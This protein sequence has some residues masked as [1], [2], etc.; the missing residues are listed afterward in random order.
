VR[1]SALRIII[2]GYVGA[3]PVGG[4]AWDYLQ[5]AIGL[6]RLGHDVLYHE[7]SRLWPYH[8][9]ENQRVG[10]ADYSVAYI[11]QFFQAF[12]PE[13]A[14]RWHYRHR[15]AT[16][17][18]ISEAE[19]RRF[20]QSA[21]LFLNVSG[22]SRIPTDL[23]PGCIKAYLDT[24]PG[25]NQI[26]IAEPPSWYEDAA[27]E[28]ELFGAYDR[29]LTYAENVGKKDCLVPQLGVDWITTRI[30]IVR[31]FWS[32]CPRPPADAAW[33][34]IMTWNAFRGPLIYQGREYGSK[35]I[36]F[37]R[38][39]SLPQKTSVTLELAVGGG[40][41]EHELIR[42]GWRV[43]N[44][45][46]VTATPGTYRDFIARSRGEISTAKNIYVAMRTGWFSCRSACYLAAGRPAIVQ[47]TGFSKYIPTG[48]G[49]IAFDTVEQAHS[50]IDVVENDYP[51]H[52]AAAKD[53]AAAYFDS[54]IVLSHMLSEIFKGG[55]SMGG[56]N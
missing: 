42:H 21:D 11:D 3:F 15:G 46:A 53:I 31:S 19:F 32:G 18:G 6:K 25:Y 10:T 50:A 22:S 23:R 56:M 16:S 28:A 40:A 41:P 24:D 1:D 13:L 8:P 45:P 54:E 36:E 52:A 20:A 44:G 55:R 48:E 43:V 17:F 30:P 7:D 35:N 33:S 26:L 14:G 51:K 5:Y 47:D 12:A 37:A 27:R 38:I 29:H 4:V 39:A 34:T 49:L 2:T 9:L